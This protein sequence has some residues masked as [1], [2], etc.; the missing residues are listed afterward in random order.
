MGPRMQNGEHLA[1]RLGLNV[2]LNILN[3]KHR[4]DHAHIGIAMTGLK[5][6]IL[7]FPI[8]FTTLEICEFFWMLMSF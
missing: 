4:I 7:S 8:I 5:A 1:R 6:F 2:Q 3:G